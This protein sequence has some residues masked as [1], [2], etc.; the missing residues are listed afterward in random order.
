MTQKV[1]NLPAMQETP[2]LGQG[3]SLE[4]LHLPWVRRSHGEGN[5]TQPISL[6]GEVHGQRNLVAYSLWSCKE[7]D[8]TEQLTVSLLSFLR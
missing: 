6:P 8:M 5:A 4:T 2:A 3:S 7:L 1:N